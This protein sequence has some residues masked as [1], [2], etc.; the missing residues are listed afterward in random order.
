MK[1][2]I[3]S[4]SLSPV[5]ID[6]KQPPYLQIENDTNTRAGQNIQLYPVHQTNHQ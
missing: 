5:M 3:P 1:L 4:K 2:R 6:L